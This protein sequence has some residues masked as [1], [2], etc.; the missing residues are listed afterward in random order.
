M[1]WIH[2]AHD[3]VQSQA[4]VKM[5][6]N[7]QVLY[8]VGTVLTSWGAHVSQ[9]G[10]CSKKLVVLLSVTNCLQKPTVTQYSWN[11]LAFVET[12]GSLLFSLSSATWIQSCPFILDLWNP[13]PHPNFSF[14]RAD[15]EAI[16]NLCF[17]LKA[18]LW[19]SCPN[20][21]ANNYLCYREN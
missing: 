21:W 1:E 8:S 12:K 7:L 5:L 9:E 14:W 17:I 3:R 4:F 20:L 10:P 2:L 16:Y 6:M 13:E 15:Y 19:K 18:K 11:S